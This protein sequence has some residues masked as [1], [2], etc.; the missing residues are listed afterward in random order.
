M[1]F[2]AYLKMNKRLTFD[3]VYRVFCLKY[4]PTIY[5]LHIPV[6]ETNWFSVKLENNWID[7]N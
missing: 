6:R 4:I 7:F 5:N 2:K 1:I 3:T